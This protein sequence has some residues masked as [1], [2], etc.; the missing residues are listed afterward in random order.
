MSLTNSVSSYSTLSTR[1]GLGGL[2][3]GLDTEELIE[4]MTTSTR[5]KIATALQ[6]KQLAGW[7][8]ENYRTVSNALIEFK[9][10]YFSST[11][12]TNNITSAK[13]FDVAA[14]KNTSSYVSISGKA[15]QAENFQIQKIEQLATTAKYTATSQLTSQKITTGA[16]EENW[17]ADTVSGKYLSITS[18]DYSASLVIPSD[19]TFSDEAVADTT[20]KKRV[21]E[22]VAALQEKLSSSALAGKVSIG[23]NEDGTQVAIVNLL[24]DTIP[25]MSVTSNSDELLAGLGFTDEQE[26]TGAISGSAVDASQLYKDLS[27]GETLK[28]TTLS[29]TLNGI[30]KNIVFDASD[31]DDYDT[32]DELQAYLQQKLN[33]A[34]G[35][36]GSTGKVVVELGADNKLTFTT[37]SN[38]TVDTSSVFSIDGSDSRY[39]LSADGALKTS[40]GSS[41]RISWAK[42]LEQLDAEGSF[43]MGGLTTSNSDGTYD[44]TINGVDFSFDKSA[45]LTSIISTVNKSA[46]GVKITYSTTADRIVV[47]AS[48]SGTVGN[49]SISGGNSNLAELLFGQDTVTAEGQDAKLTV[50]FDGG[51]TTTELS[52]SSNSFTVD[53]L[54]LELLG[55]T[56]EKITFSSESNV[57]ELTEKISKFVE[58]YNNIIKMT[59]EFVST[60]RDRS[61][62]PLTDE[63]EEDMSDSEIEQWTEKAKT[64][65]LY[66]DSTMRSLISDLRNSISYSVEDCSTMMHK[67]GISTEDY[68]S[69]GVLSVDKDKLTAVLTSSLDEVVKLFTTSSTT[70]STAE[71]KTRNSGVGV[72][73][74]SILKKYVSTTGED[75]I[76]VAMAGLEGDPSDYDNTMGNKID[77]YEDLLD[78]LKDRLENEEDRLWSQFSKLESALS[79]LNSMSSYFS[80]LTGTSSDS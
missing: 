23:M 67:I 19:F 6:N 39:I 26:G 63:Q 55:E 25:K 12:L 3:S 22:I 50:S 57:S 10:T 75:G 13:F 79:Q 17:V 68:E 58:D 70:G 65:L 51:A 61:Y 32:A 5:S 59:N 20:G 77:D 78:R 14:I 49:I 24:Q 35:T 62:L 40:S 73:L 80:S 27:L 44:F 21:E 60:K 29:V 56:D 36:S 76:L 37:H 15:S 1:K 53:D 9:D 33:S 74:E 48:E 38:G 18:G 64:G 45:T 34:Y 4:Q 8:Q 31:S 2:M 41:N 54:T 42:T 66:G 7:K 52:R 47:T 69:N 28:G 16:I 71:E 72:K 46:A 30:S 43:N 11:N